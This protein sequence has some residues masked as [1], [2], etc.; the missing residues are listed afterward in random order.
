MPLNKETNQILGQIFSN[1]YW[2]ITK[3]NFLMFYVFFSF[4]GDKYNSLGSTKR[5][6]NIKQKIWVISTY[7]VKIGNHL[8]DIWSSYHHHHVVPLARISLTLSRHFSLSFIASGRSSGLH[9]VSSHS[10]C[11]YVCMFELVVLLLPEHMWGYIG[12]N[13]LWARPCFSSSVPRVCF[14]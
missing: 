5:C 11:M 7:D 13:R 9:P 14:V 2:E 8:K 3:K 4:R 12:V 10:C 6:L 1:F